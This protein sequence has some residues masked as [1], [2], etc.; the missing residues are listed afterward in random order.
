MATWTARSF[1][2]ILGVVTVSWAWMGFCLALPQSAAQEQ[3]NCL[4][5]HFGIEEMHPGQRLRCTDCH[6]GDGRAETKDKAHVKPTRPIVNDERVLPL[7]YDLPYLRFVNPTNLRVVD[8]TCGTCHAAACSDVKRSLHGTTAGHLSDGMYECGILPKQGSTYALFHTTPDPALENETGIKALMP[9]PSF[10]AKKP[11]LEF[12]THYRDLPSKSCA[13]C[14]LWSPGFALRGRLGMDGDYRAEGCAAC[15]VTYA[16]DGLSKS[17]DPTID[18]FEPGHGLTHTMTT[19]IPTSTCTHCHYGDASI[20]LSFRGL[21]QL[22]PGQP[23]GPQVP[24]TTPYR[25]NR[26]FYQSDP[27]VTPADLHHTAGMACIDCHTMK[28]VMGDGQLYGQMPHAVEIECEDCHGTID[29]TTRLVT[30]R[31]NP[32]P[33]LAWKD[34]RVVLTSKLDGKEHAVKQVAHV[35]SP[36]HPDYSPRA[37]EAMTKEHGRLECYACHGAWSPNFFGFHFDRNEQFTQLDL[38]TG[39]RTPGR[40]TTTEKV[41]STMRGFYLGWNS[42]N[43]IAPYMVGFSTMGTVHD[44][45]GRVILDQV[46]PVTAAGLSGMTMIHHQLHTTSKRAHDCVDCHRSPTTLGLGSPNASFRLGRNFVYVASAR[47]LDVLALDRKKPGDSVPVATL[48]MFG[49]RDV[50]LRI[51]PLQGWAT[52]AFVAQ[53]DRGIA[54]IDVTTAAFPRRVGSLETKH[55]YASIVAAN[56][57]YVADGAG[58]VL[59]A[60]VADPAQPRL[61]ATIPVTDARALE[62]NWPHLYVA[63]WQDGLV[64]VDVTDPAHAKVV[65]TFDLNGQDD[66]G[67]NEADDIALLQLPSRPDDGN[68]FRTQ[69]RLLAG[70]ACNRNGLRVVDVTDAKKAAQYYSFDAVGGVARGRAPSLVTGVAA[71]T[72]VDLGSADGGIKTE[73]NDYFYVTVTA[74]NRVQGRVFAVRA[75][76]PRK[77]ELVGS[78]R[79]DNDAESVTIA[80]VYNPPF[81]QQLV[82]AVGGGR[83]DVIDFSKT[84]TPEALGQFGGLRGALSVAIEAMP[85]DRLV[86]ESGKPW[87]DVSHEGARFFSRQEIDTI[88]RAEVPVNRVPVGPITGDGREPDKAKERERPRQEKKP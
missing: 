13:Q 69:T 9:L 58:G 83:L 82:F 64:I 66:G 70:L 71:A 61:L 55:A 56:K 22:H 54:V 27:L 73:E 17:G 75:T 33:Q 20:G 85:R 77:P 21:A 88:L 39:E 60:D 29:Q 48:P 5:C 3:D 37:A 19:K 31:G 32:L 23:A 2:R 18:K 81:L 25:L 40:V 49:A 47:G 86:D 35:V 41:F 1:C 80:N 53:K 8:Q 45:E 26:A 11:T 38:M 68:S 15:H 74:E 87:K 16:D 34:G 43:R 57:L 36:R 24:G 4:T 76:D 65:T 72:K 67:A 51:E 46:M 50:A 84:K 7:D 63:D 62:L 30:S 59:I 42:E 78:A 14:H 44:A 52:H 12:A 79:V 28:D 6:G 10:D